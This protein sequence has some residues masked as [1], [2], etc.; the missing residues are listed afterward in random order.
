MKRPYR[1]D[2]LSH[3][4]FTVTSR[5]QVPVGLKN[6]FNYKSTYNKL[7]NLLKLYKIP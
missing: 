1:Q 5:V 7:I 2:W 3:N 4:F 6:L